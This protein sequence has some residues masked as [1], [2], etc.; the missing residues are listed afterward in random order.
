M[1]SDHVAR[2]LHFHRLRL[3]PD[4]QVG[5]DPLCIARLQHQVGEDLVFESAGCNAHLISARIEVK[6]LIVSRR[7]GRRRMLEELPWFTGNRDLR[8]HRP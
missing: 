5:I 6:K 2:R 7:A 3:R 1:S 4:G 8:H